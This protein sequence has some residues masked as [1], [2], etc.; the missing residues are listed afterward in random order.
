MKKTEDS[1]VSSVYKKILDYVASTGLRNCILFISAFVSVVAISAG[2]YTKMSTDIFKLKQ[3]LPALAESTARQ[4]EL[5]NTNLE[6]FKKEVDETMSIK[7]EKLDKKF[8]KLDEKFDTF[9]V[10]IS[11]F[12]AQ[13]TIILDYIRRDMN[14]D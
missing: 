5:I 8:E 3:D 11:G 7:I 13:Q 14:N 4:Y 12:N 10:E 6:N 2:T 1:N 9:A